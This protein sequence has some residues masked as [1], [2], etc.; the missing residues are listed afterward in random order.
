MGA[1]GHSGGA[2]AVILAGIG[3][4]VI[5]FYLVSP[6]RI[7]SH[8]VVSNEQNLFHEYGKGFR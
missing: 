6:T 5:A 4:R 3:V 7:V 1:H 8:N 2:K